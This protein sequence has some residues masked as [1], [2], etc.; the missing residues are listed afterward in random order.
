MYPLLR[1]LKMDGY[2][3]EEIG[4]R[5]GSPA[6]RPQFAPK[7]NRRLRTAALL[8][9]ALFVACFVLG[10]IACSLSAGSL[11]F[12]HV[13]DWFSGGSTVGTA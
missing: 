13:W 9:L 6:C 3:E 8:A 5:L 2:F 10:Y 4:A 12:W 7:T 1:K 11:E